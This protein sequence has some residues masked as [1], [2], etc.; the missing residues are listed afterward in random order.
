MTVGRTIQ[1]HGPGRGDGAGRHR[2]RRRRPTRSC[3]S[4]GALRAGEDGEGLEEASAPLWDW[5]LASPPGAPGAGPRRGRHRGARLL[6]H[7]GAAA[8]R[9]RLAVLMAVQRTK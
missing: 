5:L 4:A 8:A 1:T 3:P 7:A 2:G 6:V 9:K